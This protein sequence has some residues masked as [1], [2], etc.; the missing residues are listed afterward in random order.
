MCG[1]PLLEKIAYSTD[2]VRMCSTPSRR[3]SLGVNFAGFDIHRY[4]MSKVRFS[5]YFRQRY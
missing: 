2:A 4:P 1:Q 5:L 3:V